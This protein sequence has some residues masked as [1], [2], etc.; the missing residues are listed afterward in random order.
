VEGARDAGAGA[1]RGGRA[2]G[3]RGVRPR[4]RRAGCRPRATQVRPRDSTG[5]GAETARGARAGRPRGGEGEGEERERREGRGK[6]HLRGSKLRR[7]RLQTLGHHGE[8]ERWKRE[9]EVTAQE[10][11]NETNG[12]GGRRGTH[13]GRAGGARGAW[14]GPGRTG[15][16]RARPGCDASWIETHDTHDH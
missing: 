15:L 7:S 6:T 3:G 12:L 4:G 2:R 13:M 10:K 16:G 5:V 8:R 11:S 9:R 14:A 1:R